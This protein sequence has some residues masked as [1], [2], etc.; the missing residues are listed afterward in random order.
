[1]K[2]PKRETMTVVMMKMKKVL[3][4]QKQLQQK[5]WQVHST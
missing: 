4:S 5:Q 3:R 2:Q 1:M